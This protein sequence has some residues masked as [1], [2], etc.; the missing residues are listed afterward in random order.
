MQLLIV[1]HIDHLFEL[2]CNTA[3][4]EEGRTEEQWPCQATDHGLRI[5][6]RSVLFDEA[7]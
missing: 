7:R 2:G 5:L 6:V 4:E 1:M 3:E